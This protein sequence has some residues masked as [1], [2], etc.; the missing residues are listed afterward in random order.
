M[1]EWNIQRKS[2]STGKTYHPLAHP[3][4]RH[5]QNY[6]DDSVFTTL[7]EENMGLLDAIAT[8]NFIHGLTP[9][10]RLVYR[11]THKYLLTL[12]YELGNGERRYSYH[13]F[14]EIPKIENITNTLTKTILEIKS[15]GKTDKSRLVYTYMEERSLIDV[16]RALQENTVHGMLLKDFRQKVFLESTDYSLLCKEWR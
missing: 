10:I 7:E 13:L 16:A 9:R 2:Y 12:I 11:N 1:S 15:I 3:V 14:D 4:I 5:G 8:L 6:K